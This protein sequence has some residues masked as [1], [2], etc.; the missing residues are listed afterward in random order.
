MHGLGGGLFLEN[1]I[2]SNGGDMSS[3]NSVPS[4]MN[5]VLSVVPFRFSGVH[6]CD[7]IAAMPL[8]YPFAKEMLDFIEVS[9]G[10]KGFDILGIP[11]VSKRLAEESKT[12]MDALGIACDRHNVK[13]MILFQTVD[14]HSDRKQFDSQFEEDSFHKDVLIRSGEMI[15]R[16][17]SKIEASLVY[18]RL[19]NDRTEIEMVEI[20]DEGRERVRLVAPYRFKGIHVCETYLVMCMDFRFRKEARSCVRYSLKIDHFGLIGLPGSS[21][22]FLEDSESAWRSLEIAIK[23]HG[24]KRVII[25][26]HADCWAY[27][28]IDSFEGD[29]IAEE[30]AHLLDMIS[31][32]EM[33]KEK[34]PHVEVVRIYARLI[35]RG[36]KIQFVSV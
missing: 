9:Y 30:H 16:L 10:I 22:K 23:E 15:R 25:M 5:G 28:G 4:L 6:S 29:C 13:R 17:H 32:E 19:V 18:V 11:S 34:Y 26:H 3:T 7:A 2:R 33:V 1:I 27:G 24:C 20:S 21:R 8:A 31:F 14:F 12:V 35:E 36:T